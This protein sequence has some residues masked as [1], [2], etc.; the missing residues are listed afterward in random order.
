[1]EIKVKIERYEELVAKEEKLRLLEEALKAQ[2]GYTDI[3]TVKRLFG[4]QEE[5]NNDE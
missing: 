5:T 4:L 2:S 1:M 3:D